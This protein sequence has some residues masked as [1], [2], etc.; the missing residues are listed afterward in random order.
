MVIA[1]S[2]RTLRSSSDDSDQNSDTPAVRERRRP[3]RLADTASAREEDQAD[4]IT[5]NW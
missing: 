3:S 5:L 2:G 4:A 1:L